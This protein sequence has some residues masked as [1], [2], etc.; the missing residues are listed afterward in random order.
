MFRP[1][2]S[3]VGRIET[4]STKC[5]LCM[6]PLLKLKTRPRARPVSLMLSMKREREREKEGEYLFS[7]GMTCV[8]A[9]FSY[10][11]LI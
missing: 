10:L 4:L 1:F 6:Q 9:P 11:V 2:N 3:K 5:M 8:L 7:K